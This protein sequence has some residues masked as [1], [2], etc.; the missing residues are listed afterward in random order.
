MKTI[1]QRLDFELEDGKK[2]FKQFYLNNTAI[3]ELPENTFGDITFNLIN[4]EIASNLSLIHTFA[5]SA[6]NLCLKEF[7]VCNLPLTN[8]PPNHDIFAAV[9]LM[10]AIEKIWICANSQI[11]NLPENAFRPLLGHQKNLSALYL[12]DNNIDHIPKNVFNFLKKS[13]KHFF[14]NLYS[15][16]L[17]DS[18]FE[19][20]PRL[21]F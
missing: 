12:Y 6:N 8:E 11:K 21:I 16:N 20:P 3:S 15:N 14:I 19:V 2:Y 7:T 1:F 5:F 17:N 10:V 9:S 4:I 13:E 18:S